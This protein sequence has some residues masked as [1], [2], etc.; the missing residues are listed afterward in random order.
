MK[1]IDYEG[2]SNLKIEASRYMGSYDITVVNEN[3]LS[4]PDEIVSSRKYRHGDII[5]NKRIDEFYFFIKNEDEKEW[6]KVKE[7]EYNDIIEFLRKHIKE[8][9]DNLKEMNKYDKVVNYLKRYKINIDRYLGTFSNTNSVT[10][11]PEKIPVG[12]VIHVLKDGNFY[13]YESDYE[14]N[15]S[16]KLLIEVYDEDI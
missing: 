3:Q 13:N 15:K 14:G 10:L 4:S 9:E 11:N 12:S 6:Y 1:I 8:C 2:I 16:W 7:E 5:H